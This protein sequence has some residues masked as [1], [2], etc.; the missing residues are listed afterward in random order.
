MYNIVIWYFHILQNAH[1]DKFSYHLSPYKGITLLLTIFPMLY[2]S[3]PWLIY[4]VT[5]S[6]YLLI[7]L[8]YVAHSPTSSPLATSCLFSVSM[9]LFLFCYLYLFCFLDFTYKWNHL[10]FV[11]LWLTSLS[12]TP[13]RFIH[14]VANRKIS[15]LWLS[16][17]PLYVYECVCIIF[18][19]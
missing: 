1:H 11:F 18:F 5:E 7:S 17:I 15:F 19:F 6:V 9:I 16:N 13:S 12:I 14:P 3:S 10:V 4:F 8:T 2:I